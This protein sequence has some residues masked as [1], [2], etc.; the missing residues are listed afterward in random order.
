MFL[1][2]IY[3]KEMIQINNL[4]SNS[5]KNINSLNA[6]AKIGDLDDFIFADQEIK[7][8]SDK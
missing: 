3:Q 5:I 7:I 2:K 8:S 6:N 1:L 4:S